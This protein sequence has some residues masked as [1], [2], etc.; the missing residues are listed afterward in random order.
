MTSMQTNGPGRPTLAGEPSRPIPLQSD[1]RADNHIRSVFL[2]REMIRID[3]H[4]Q[5]IAM[6]LAVPVSAYRGVSLSLQRGQGNELSYQLH[7]VHNDGEL[8][9]ALDEAADDRDILAD[10][11]LWTRFFGLPALVERQQG[12]IEPAD[13]ALGAL[14]LG[15]GLPDR[16]TSR[17]GRTRRPRFLRRRKVGQAEAG[18]TIVEGRE[19]IARR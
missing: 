16:R 8:S 19:L 18:S 6:R 17:S 14:L 1:I 11:R 7:L 5:G 9:V 15:G 2:T 3:R 10:W 13:L 4:L 12:Q